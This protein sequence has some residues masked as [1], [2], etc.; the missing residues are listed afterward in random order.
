[1]TPQKALNLLIQIVESVSMPKAGHVQADEAITVLSNYI[2]EHER[3]E[4]TKKSK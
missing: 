4:S 3:P 2:E 1:M